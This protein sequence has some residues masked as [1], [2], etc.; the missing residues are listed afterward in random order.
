MSLEA[1][2]NV[3]C[4]RIAKGAV[5]GSN[6]NNSRNGKQQLP[7]ENACVFIVGRKETSDPRKDLKQQIGTVQGKTYYTSREKRKGGMD[8]AVFDMVAWD[9]VKSTLKGPSKMF[10]MWYSKQGS[11]FCG[12]GYWTSRLEKG[13]DSRCPSCR[14]L[15]ESMDHLN[16]C[17]NEARTAVFVDQIA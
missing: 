12:V 5:K 10:K 11:G 7:L 16:Q 6:S 1:Q 17:K 8:A 13:E 14:K 3:E 9:D 2:L 4:D 15:N